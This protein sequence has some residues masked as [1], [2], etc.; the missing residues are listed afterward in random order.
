MLN[1]DSLIKLIK[2]KTGHQEGYVI[3][4]YLNDLLREDEEIRNL[5]AEKVYHAMNENEEFI[6]ETK[7]QKRDRLERIGRG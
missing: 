2:K 3:E 1:V 6:N 5:I 4:L 7:A